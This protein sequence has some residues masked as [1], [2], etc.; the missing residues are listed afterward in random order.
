MGVSVTS[1]KFVVFDGPSVIGRLGTFVNLSLISESS[2]YICSVAV[3]FC[4]TQTPI[5]V[6]SADSDVFEIRTSQVSC[7]A[8]TV[9]VRPAAK[10]AL[11]GS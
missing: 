7:F 8:D 1:L 4:P 11:V 5:S 2:S 3:Y 9:I 10:S 6:V